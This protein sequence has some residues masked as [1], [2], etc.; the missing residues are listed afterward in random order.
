MT[1]PS[2]R[3]LVQIWSSQTAPPVGTWTVR[4]GRVIAEGVDFSA[5][6]AL[7]GLGG[8]RSAVGEVRDA[9]QM[10]ARALR[11]RNGDI[12]SAVVEAAMAARGEPPARPSALAL[13]LLAVLD[14]NTTTIAIPGRWARSRLQ[15]AIG[16]AASVAALLGFSLNGAGLAGDVVSPSVAGLGPGLVLAA[17]LAGVAV[18][19]LRWPVI[20][21]HQD[22]RN[23]GHLPLRLAN[24]YARYLEA[25]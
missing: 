6:E 16:K 21:V 4:G 13:W 14:E 8:A 9:A 2:R 5:E 18:A 11:I 22:G 7:A 19:Y 3:P 23:L 15:V 17:G 12:T 25:E 20:K 24:A 10:G 1:E